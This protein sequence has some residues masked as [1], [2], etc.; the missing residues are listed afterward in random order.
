MTAAGRCALAL[1]ALALL[2]LFVPGPVHA[3]APHIAAKLAAESPAPLPGGSTTV[4]L[5]MTPE[6]GWH[7][8]WS[9]GGD[10]GFGMQVEWNLPDG[11][12]VAP[13]R[14]PVPEALILFGMMN[15]VYEHPYAL[16]ADVRVDRSVAPGSDLTLTGI[17]N[18]LACTDKICVPEKAVIS[19]AMRAGDGAVAPAARRQFDG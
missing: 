19:V 7:G 3:A 18:W 6:P 8:Y 16:L 12:T 1:L 11:V 14:Y 2:V 4:A 13:F 5:V 15:H 17:A 10:A 9:N